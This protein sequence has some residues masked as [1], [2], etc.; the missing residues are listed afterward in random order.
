MLMTIDGFGG[1]SLSEK[2]KVLRLPWDETDKQEPL[3]TKIIR[4]KKES[5]LLFAF[6]ALNSSTIFY[7]YD[8]KLN[9]DE[10]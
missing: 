8:Q 10:V 7:L 9:F 2:T 5:S 1:L 6:S 3:E 4:I